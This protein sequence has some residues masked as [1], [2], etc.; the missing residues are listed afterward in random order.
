MIMQAQKCE[1][2]GTCILKFKT[3]SQL[4]CFCDVVTVL[5]LTSWGLHPTL[6]SE[7]LSNTIQNIKE[8]ELNKM[9]TGR[10]VVR[11]FCF[12][13]KSIFLILR[14]VGYKVYGCQY[15]ENIV[16]KLRKTAEHCDCLQCFFIIH[17]MGGGKYIFL[18]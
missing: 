10:L 18:C 4:P 13:F 17:S 6:D 15:R 11:V 2:I 3:T 16:E 14:A 7:L 5:Q 9:K 12:V 1:L 8:R